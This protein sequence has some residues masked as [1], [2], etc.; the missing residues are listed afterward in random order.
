MSGWEQWP[1]ARRKSCIKGDISSILTPPASCV[2]D[3]Y[4]MTYLYCLFG[5]RFEKAHLVCNDFPCHFSEEIGGTTSPPMLLMTVCLEGT[6]EF[7]LHLC[8]I[9]NCNDVGHNIPHAH[10]LIQ[11][12]LFEVHKECEIPLYH[13]HTRTPIP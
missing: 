3:N 7:T 10:M 5:A 12:Q 1:S 11:K 9:C 13:R 8:E 6:W 2:D 4:Y